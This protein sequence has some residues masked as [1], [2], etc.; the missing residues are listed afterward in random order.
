MIKIS[1]YIFLL[2]AVFLI[3]LL[4]YRQF[5]AYKSPIFLPPAENYQDFVE[6]VP[7]PVINNKPTTST[8][9]IATTTKKKD[10]I[11]QVLPKDKINLNIPFT[12]QA[13]TANWVQPFEDACE[14][15]SIL[16]VDYY[17]SKK[18]MPSKLAVED[19]LV[20]MVKWQ[21][22][23]W[24]EHANLSLAKMLEYVNKNYNY[25]SEIIDNPSIDLIKQ[26]LSKGLPIIVPANGKKLANPNFRE[27][28]PAYHM[29]VIK[30][31]IDDKFITNDPGTRLGADFIY[32]QTNLM[33][34]IADW[35]GNI[36]GASGSKRILILHK[37]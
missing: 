23:N 1:R 32:T 26:Y 18:T 16:M 34:S 28:G 31:Y 33:S 5:F 27:G 22:D 11:P 21:E 30:G 36:D 20:D 6:L 12:S 37:I 3:S 9:V 35:D 4:F 19:I 10:D 25:R 7:E 17:Y 15:A 14:E 13:P 29:L 24:G 8:N 2:L